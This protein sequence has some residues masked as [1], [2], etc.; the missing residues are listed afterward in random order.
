LLADFGSRSCVLILPSCGFAVA[1]VVLGAT[2]VDGPTIR[3]R[4]AKAQDLA[5]FWDLDIFGGRGES[6]AGFFD[7]N[8]KLK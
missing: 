4:T 8:L 2:S 7:Q 1:L 5:C 3:E 6:V